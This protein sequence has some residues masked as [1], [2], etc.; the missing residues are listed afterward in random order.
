MNISPQKMTFLSAN[1]GL[2]PAQI[3]AFAHAYQTAE[4]IRKKYPNNKE[5]NLEKLL[6]DCSTN[7]CSISF[8]QT[9]ST[10][11]WTLWYYAV[12]NA[13]N[14]LGPLAHNQ[15]VLVDLA[16][17][18]GSQPYFASSLTNESNLTLLWS[19]ASDIHSGV[20]GYYVNLTSIDSNQIVSSRFVTTI[21]L[22]IFLKIF[23][24]V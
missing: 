24:K 22:G 17:P 6:P 1:Y 10:G 21:S 14:A 9:L 15:F 7:T 12:D 11:N 4:R 20:S 23:L 13:G 19:S 16:P 8:N 5:I 2:S 3:E 18:V